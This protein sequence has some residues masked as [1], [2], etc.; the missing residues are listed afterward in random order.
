MDRLF[1]DR[2]RGCLIGG[3]V[4][5][6]LGY[7]VEFDSLSRIRQKY[8][9]QGIQAYESDPQTG[10]AI[11]SDDTQM[12]MFTANGL[13]LSEARGGRPVEEWIYEAYLD[14]L[15]TQFS[16]PKQPVCWLNGI[17]ELNVRRAPG[18]TCLQALSSGEMG[19]VD[20]PINNSK[21]C[22]GVMRVAP[23]AIYGLRKGWDLERID[24]LGAAAAA[25]THGHSLGYMSAAALVDIVY[26]ILDGETIG[27]AVCV[28]ANFMEQL[29]PDDPSM[30]KLVKGM[31]LAQALAEDDVRTDLECLGLLGEGWV[32]EETLFVAIYCALKYAN[33]FDKAMIVS[34]N[35]G[36]DSDSTGAVAGN[37][38][39]AYVGDEAIPE[40]WKTQ[41]ELRETILELAD[42]LCA[43]ENERT[44]AWK[45]KYAVGF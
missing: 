17:P 21:G 28:S 7:A 44:A 13:L 22:G 41:L 31:R 18:N 12:T 25:I 24:R 16:G 10:M 27:N 5:D 3:A 8:G 14:W 43:S 26:R 6:A 45:R 35:H 15:K 30:P 29:Y 1:L 37:I 42:D 4:G 2:A 23:V 19:R 34:V 40:K 20:A 38:L 32:G 39:G 36:G 11:I 9:Q 33:D